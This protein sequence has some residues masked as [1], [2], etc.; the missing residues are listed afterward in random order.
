MSL[1]LVNLIKAFYFT[2]DSN[3]KSP[4]VPA[5]SLFLVPLCVC[6]VMGTTLRVLYS[7]IL[8]GQKWL[9]RTDALASFALAGY[10]GKRFRA[11]AITPGACVI[12]LIT[13]VI[14]LDSMVKP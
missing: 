11:R 6:L 9:L 5:S 14:Y 7:S 12:K 8:Q 2:T 1:T 3:T 4:T 10:E 13:T